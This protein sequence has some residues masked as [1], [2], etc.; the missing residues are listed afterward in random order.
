[1]PPIPQPTFPDGPLTRLW[2]AILLKLT[3]DPVLKSRVKTWQTW[4]GDS[5][6]LQSIPQ[7]ALPAIRLTW[8]FGEFRFADECRYEGPMVIDFEYAVGRRSGRELLNFWAAVARCL[9]WK[10]EWMNKLLREHR[11]YS[12]ILSTPAA[13]PQVIASGQGLAARG[14]ITITF[15]TDI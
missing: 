10:G 12:F 15:A 2:D 3:T 11:V 4:E 5:D 8:G 7:T 14:R 1:M 9:S 6:D 13:A